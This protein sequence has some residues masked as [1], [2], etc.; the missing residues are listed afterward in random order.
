MLGYC[1][2]RYGKLQT[3]R[4]SADELVSLKLFESLCFYTFTAWMLGEVRSFV[5]VSHLVVLKRHKRA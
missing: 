1:E 4:R 2:R 3:V 5:E